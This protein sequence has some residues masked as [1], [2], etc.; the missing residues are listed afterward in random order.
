MREAPLTTLMARGK[1][2][3][4]KGVRHGADVATRALGVATASLRPFPDFLIVG[5]KRGG[6]TSM[7]SYLAQHPQVI[8]MFPAARGLKSNS[9][10][11]KNWH[12]GDLW[13]RSHFHTRVYRRL[14]ERRLGPTVTGE[15]SPYY[16]YGPHVPGRIARVMPHARLVV[17]LRNPVD[18]AYSHYQERVKEGFE[19]LSFEDALAAESER[20]DGEWERMERNTGYYSTAHDFFTY[21]DRGVYLPQLQR[22]HAAFPS[23]QVL[24]IRSED[25]YHDAQGVVDT[26][27]G[28]LGISP[29]GIPRPVRH[30]YI[31]RA[32]IQPR[33]RRDL[34]QFYAPHNE[35]LYT[36]LGRDLAW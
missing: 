1:H 5:T 18:R 27:C 7:W 30:N 23:E 3:V 6:T 16:M 9:Y 20:L 12:R 17:L 34:E 36:Y 19:P 32:P 8:P 35:A 28:F 25:L 15:A 26:V 21:R 4:P 10:F 22:L 13:Y 14:R 33:T 31:P 11:F 29:F 24:V 2:R